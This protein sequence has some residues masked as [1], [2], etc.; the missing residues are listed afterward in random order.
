MTVH[1]KKV[2]KQEA[3]A[4]KG[5]SLANSIRDGLIGA[6]KWITHP[7]EMTA[8]NTDTGK[9]LSGAKNPASKQ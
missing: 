9:I 1:S 8:A 5:K 7:V 6:K 2:H 4:T 3:T